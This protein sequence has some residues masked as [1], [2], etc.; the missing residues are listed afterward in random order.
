MTQSCLYKYTQV[1]PQTIDQTSTQMTQSYLYKYTKIDETFLS[2]LP[3]CTHMRQKLVSF[4]HHSVLTDW[5]NCICVHLSSTEWVKIKDK[6]SL[7]SEP[8]TS[9]LILCGEPPCKMFPFNVS[10]WCMQFLTSYLIHK[11]VWPGAS[12]KVQKGP[13]KVNIKHLWD[14]NG[15]NIIIMLQHD[16]CISCI[17]KTVWPNASLKV[18]KVMQRSTLNMFISYSSI[19]PYTQINRYPLYG[20]KSCPSEGV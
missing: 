5:A 8:L 16:V 19:F 10:T 9:T 15:P 7:R 11:A 2:L 4:S 17:H 1:L 20:N 13:T 12:S 6:T 14:F 3:P 18:Q